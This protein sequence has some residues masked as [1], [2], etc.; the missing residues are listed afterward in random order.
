VKGWRW[1]TWLPPVLRYQDGYM[2][3]RFLTSV[4]HCDGHHDG[5]AYWAGWKRGQR[6]RTPDS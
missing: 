5:R 4:P 6:E 1:L 2:H 3:A